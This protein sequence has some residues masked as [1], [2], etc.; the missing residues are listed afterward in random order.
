MVS[1]WTQFAGLC[2]KQEYSKK[3]IDLFRKAKEFAEKR[4]KETKRLSG[5]NQIDHNIE[6]GRILVENKLF[7]EVVIAGILSK[8]EEH[9]KYEEVEK[10]FGKEIADLVFAQESISE[11]EKKNKFTQGEVLRKIL[12]LTF[13]DMRIIFIKLASKLDNLRTVN[14]LPKDQKEKVIKEVFEVYAPL[15]GRLGLEKIKRG[16]EDRALKETEPEEYKRIEEFISK[17][18]PQRENFIGKAIKEISR[19][20]KDKVPEFHIK[21]R[22]KSIYSIYKKTLDKGRCLEEQRDFFGIRVI[23]NTKEECYTVLGILLEKYE[24]LDGTF[25]DYIRNPKV[26]GYQSLH[27]TLKFQD[28]MLEVQVRTK[29]MNEDAEEGVAAHWSYKQTA[30]DSDFE[31][32]IGWLKSVIDLQLNKK[33]EEVLKTIKVDLFG[34]RIYCYTP[35]GDLI[36]LPKDSTVLDFAYQVHD[37]LGNRAVAGRINNK[38]SSLK[39]KLVQGDIVEII[40]NKNQR[41]RREWLNFVV[42]R[43]AID[44]I[45]KEIKKYENLGVSPRIYI[46]KQEKEKCDPLVYSEDF[47]D[48]ELSFAKCCFPIPDRE[49]VGVEKSFKKISVHDK[50]CTKLGES[51][52]NLIPIFWKDKP[53]SIFIVNIET[54]E[55]SGVLA[56]LLNILVSEKFVIKEAK[57]KLVCPGTIQ[58]IFTLFPKDITAIK[59]VIS[60]I[61]KVEGF[62]KIY[63]GDSN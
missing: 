24:S 27:V 37:D 47:P 21:G 17:F 25:K 36:S 43:K 42:S 19:N 38:F 32:K 49:L 33:D 55:R 59:R 54:H 58:S 4:L 50:E 39:T 3:D 45:R 53:D 46:K 9:A 40:V 12:L 62:K 18:K 2:R 35:K 15:A 13:S 23:V 52:K 28:K 31:R 5:E 8:I 26:N 41:P 63:F 30:T 6:V 60:R 44:T 11:I 7:A 51:A 16:L 10:E 61:S 29:E 34:E 1:N 48:S 56:E 20:I 57:A 14:V 22:E